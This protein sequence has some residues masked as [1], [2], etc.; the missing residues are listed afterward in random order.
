MGD[1]VISYGNAE[2]KHQTQP[3]NSPPAQPP[4]EPPSEPPAQPPAQPSL[5]STENVSPVENVS[6]DETS[7]QK[8]NIIHK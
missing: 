6:P 7:R 4:S 1:G 8:N 2:D 5:P 3:N